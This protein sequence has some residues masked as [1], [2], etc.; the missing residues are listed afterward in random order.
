MFYKTGCSRYMSFV[1]S[2]G[3]NYESHYF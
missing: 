3:Q 1:W 2:F